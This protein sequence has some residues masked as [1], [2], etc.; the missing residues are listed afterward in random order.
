MGFGSIGA[1][2]FLAHVELL[3]R[4]DGKPVDHH[5]GRF[6]IARHSGFERIECGDEHLVHFLDEIVA[7]LVEAVDG[8]LGV[9]DALG[10]EIV[11]AG[12]VFLVPE[13]EIPQV[14]F[15]HEQEEFRAASSGQLLVPTGGEGRLEGGDF[16][17]VEVHRRV[18]KVLTVAGM[19]GGGKP[20][21][22]RRRP[23]TLIH[24]GADPTSR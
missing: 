22:R 2:S 12:D 4:E 24:A 6:R 14:I 21:P 1:D 9:M 19:R 20:E 13:L 16:F 18:E 3:E 5:S 10:A 17:R 15:L 8:A 23:A 7:L 11:A